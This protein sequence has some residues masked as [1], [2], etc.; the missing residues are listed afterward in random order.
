MPDSTACSGPPLFSI[1]E[2]RGKDI[3]LVPVRD[4]Q[5]G[6]L[7]RVDINAHGNDP[8]PPVFLDPHKAGSLAVFLSNWANTQLAE[9]GD[10]HYPLQPPPIPDPPE[11]APDRVTTMG[12]FAEYLR[13]SGG[14]PIPPS[15][16][17]EDLS[18]EQLTA[19][20]EWDAA[21]RAEE[22]MYVRALS[23][24][25]DPILPPEEDPLFETGEGLY[26]GKNRL[27]WADPNADGPMALRLMR[28]PEGH[29]SFRIFNR[30]AKNEE[31]PDDSSH[32]TLATPEAV[33]GIGA[34]LLETDNL[35]AP[36]P[37]ETVEGAL[38]FFKVI[39][40]AV[41]D[42]NMPTKSPD[43]FEVLAEPWKDETFIFG[44]DNHYL[45]E[46]WDRKAC[47]YVWEL[48][49][50]GGAIKTSY[51][52]IERLLSVH[53]HWS[54]PQSF[55]RIITGN[56]LVEAKMRRHDSGPATIEGLT[57]S[58]VFSRRAGITFPLNFF[59]LLALTFFPRRPGGDR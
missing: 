6:T 32:W 13:K 44:V 48:L 30:E 19:L 23:E 53:T 7:L 25:N 17:L 8:S 55:P 52:E 20:G 9:P 3:T 2:M 27:D 1:E 33:K 50:P 56:L 22:M 29:V 16:K 4:S 57:I 41:Q 54:D 46:R 49:Y 5:G 45:A 40:E 15:R 51:M 24:P 14:D 35:S 58:E 26:I 47:Q 11:G 37:P 18:P 10:L 12:S 59:T 34:F 31:I 39:T 28:S 21:K 38:D 42:R 36:F 43:D